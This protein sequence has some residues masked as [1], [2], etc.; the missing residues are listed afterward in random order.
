MNK[1]FLIFLILS[2]I[3]ITNCERKGNM[4]IINKT[5]QNVYYRLNNSNENIVLPGDS[6]HIYN[7]SLGK[8][9]LFTKPE[10][11]IFFNY[12]AGETF[13]L[14]GDFTQTTVTIKS[15]KTT[16]LYLNPTHAGIKIIN[17]SNK[18]ITSLQ[19]IMHKGIVI[20][21]S[22]NLILDHNLTPDNERYFRIPYY[23]SLEQNIENRFYYQ[24][25]VQTDDLQVYTFGDSTVVLD[26]GEQ[27]IIDFNP[28]K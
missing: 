9:T 14:D 20:K 25:K 24:F 1:L 10:K 3:I 16:R 22:G 8:E 18:V 26:K 12:I 11:T 27:Y 23:S 15:E 2:T 17:N 19:T 5:H 21:E 13:S 7:Y 4:E 28:L 6:T